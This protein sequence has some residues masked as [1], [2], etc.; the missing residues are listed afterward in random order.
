MILKSSKLIVI[1]A[2]VAALGSSSYAQDAEPVKWYTMEQVEELVKKE[3]R[4]I[5]IDMYTDWCGWCK[6]MDKKTFTN[7]DISNHLNSNFYAVKFDAEGN[8]PVEFKG[9][10]FNFVA[11]G[12]KGY[13]E[14]AAALMQGK[15]SYPTSV[16]LDENLNLITPLPGYYPPEKLQPI[17]EFIGENHY[18]TTSYEQ[19]LSK[20]GGVSN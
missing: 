11:Q 10:T 4:K 2:I 20:R 14:L 1:V 7:A 18:K 8:R 16:F 5:Y 17:L 13:H 12:R 3:P 15:M 9:Q 19:Y 6:V